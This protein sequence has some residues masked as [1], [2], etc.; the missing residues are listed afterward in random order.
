M[1]AITSAQFVLLLA[2]LVSGCMGWQSTPLPSPTAQGD[3]LLLGTLRV[4]T[5]PGTEL[6]PSRERMV[7][8]DVRVQDDSLIGWG[9][10]RL[11]SNLRI[12]VH[13]DQVLTLENGR[14]DWGRTGTIA[15][16][17]V[18]SV[19]AVYGVVVLYLLSTLE[20]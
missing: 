20:V 7:L 15:G 13:R 4:T 10:T 2:L 14:V 9:G 6:A 5:R 8:R 18:L 11:D 16:V 19:V 12:A 1:R 17:V 3:S